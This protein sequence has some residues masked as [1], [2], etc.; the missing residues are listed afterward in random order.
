[1]NPLLIGPLMK[2]GESL[3]G[4]F[5]PD[6]EAKR[7]AEAEFLKMAAEGELKQIVAQLEINAKEAAHPTIWVAGWR[8]Y[9]GWV[10]GT[11]FAYAVLAQ[12]FLTW[13]AAIKGWPTPPSVDVDLLWVVLS[14]LLGIGSLRTFEKAKGVATK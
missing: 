14:G 11:G 5:F 1:M 13:V 8:P 10:G 9:V 7:Q 4:R 2:L 6:P 12:P 3:I